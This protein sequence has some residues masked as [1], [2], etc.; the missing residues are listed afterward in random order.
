[1]YFYATL[2]LCVQLRFNLPLVFPAFVSIHPSVFTL[3]NIPPIVCSRVNPSTMRR[4]LSSIYQPTHRSRFSS[5]HLQPFTSA[6]NFVCRLCSLL[7]IPSVHKCACINFC[8]L[9]VVQV[10]TTVFPSRFLD[11][12][13]ALC[14]SF[15]LQFIHR[16]VCPYMR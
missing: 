12:F 11:V 16:F 14:Y 4:S 1:M 8:W 13:W 10:C 3:I 7:L 9:I 2:S 6:Y 5:F 15:R